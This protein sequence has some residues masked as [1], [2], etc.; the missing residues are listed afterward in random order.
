MSG[1][2]RYDVVIV[3]AGAGGGTVAAALAPLARAGRRVL[4]L[5]RGTRHA[6]EAAVFDE[7]RATH[8]SYDHPRVDDDVVRL[9]T[10]RGVGG[11]TRV[12]SGV[13]AAPGG[14][15]VA[16]WNVPGLDAGDL[17]GRLVR[18]AE[19]CG[20]H[21]LPPDALNENHRL[22]ADGAARAGFATGAYRVAVRGCRGAA[23]CGLGCPNDAVQ[24]T[25]R[26]QLPVAEAAGVEVITGADVL[27]VRD[28][29]LEVRVH[30]PRPGE[31]DAPWAPGTHLVEAGCVVLAAGAIGTPA[32]LLRSGLGRALPR[33]G[34]GI[35]LHPTQWIAAEHPRPITTDVGHPTSLVLDR[36]ETDGWWLEPAF[37]PPL[38]TA[39]H[40]GG[41]GPRHEAMLR[42]FPRLQMLRAVAIDRAADGHRV[43]LDADGEPLVQYRLTPAVRRALVQAQRSAT[44]L[45]FAAGA[46][47]VHAPAAIEAPLERRDID[48]IDARLPIDGE[49]LGPVTAVHAMGGAAMGRD[50]ATSVTDAWGRV[51]GMP[52][53]RIADA[54][55][56]PDALGVPPALMVMALADRV[57]EG[58]QADGGALA[59]GVA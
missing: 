4:L 40:L 38:A 53:L 10:G 56:C 48:H 20:A 57:A 50:A 21:F 58:V 37:A 1:R 24:G 43:T 5:E 22:F 54:S 26:V 13:I 17:E 39:L 32:L 47:R 12:S 28:R 7:V 45:A 15:S 44:R 36:S 29:R 31:P 11:S 51:H 27:A 9:A 55:L 18:L 35:T 33:L 19:T 16:A 49:R 25:H 34:H 46:V 52:W 3:G 6:P 30:A 59:E 42:A 2:F 14:R 41:M 23:V 8:A